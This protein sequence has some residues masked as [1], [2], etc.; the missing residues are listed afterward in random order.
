LRGFDLG[1]LKRTD[2]IE[3][4][5]LF[6]GS[7]FK[8]TLCGVTRSAWALSGCSKWEAW[9]GTEFGTGALIST[10]SVLFLR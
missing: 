7:L 5:G 10:R 1:D 6:E 9:R 8:T 2:L 3:T 4:F